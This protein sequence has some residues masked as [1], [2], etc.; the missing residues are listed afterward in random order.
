M[1]GREPGKGNIAAGG[2]QIRRDP[3]GSSRAEIYYFL[4]SLILSRT[5]P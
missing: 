5:D 1:R 4:F 2:H 3:Q